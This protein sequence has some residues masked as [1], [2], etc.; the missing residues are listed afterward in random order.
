MHRGV[1]NQKILEQ[2]KLLRL[3]LTEKTTA[4]DFYDTPPISNFET[5]I[6]TGLVNDKMFTNL[7]ENC[8]HHPSEGRNNEKLEH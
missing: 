2:K 5:D 6:A 8:F 4:V 3:F 1:Q 7:G